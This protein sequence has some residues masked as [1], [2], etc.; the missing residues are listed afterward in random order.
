MNPIKRALLDA[1]EDTLVNGDICTAEYKD[2]LEGGYT[3]FEQ[4]KA[5]LEDVA[6]QNPWLASVLEHDAEPTITKL[7]YSI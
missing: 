2:P 3:V 6:L 5:A 1:L 7:E 4:V